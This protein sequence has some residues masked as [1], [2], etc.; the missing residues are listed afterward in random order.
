VNHAVA[1]AA[2]L[3]FAECGQPEFTAARRV[4]SITSEHDGIVLAADTSDDFHS[5]MTVCRSKPNPRRHTRLQNDLAGHVF[6]ALPDIQH[7]R[8]AIMT[9]FD[10]IDAE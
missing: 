8:T 3:V 6:L 7:W 2:Q 1:A 10:L 5:G 4:K 9:S